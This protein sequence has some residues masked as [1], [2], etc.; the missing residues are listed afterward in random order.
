MNRIFKVIY[1]KVK[2][3][4]VVTSEF[5]KTNKKTKTSTAVKA[6]LLA[7]AI[8]A[9]FA[10]FPVGVPS[11]QAADS[12]TY[13]ESTEKAHQQITLDGPAGEGTLI[14]NLKNGMKAKGSTDAITGGQLWD[15]EQYIDEVK[16]MVTTNTN[17]LMKVNK[18]ISDH[19]T[20]L[21]QYSNRLGD[22]ENG[23]TIKVNGTEVNELNINNKSLKFGNTDTISVASDNNGTL[24]FNAATGQVE[25]DNNGLVTGDMVMRAIKKETEG[26]P[27]DANVANKL[28]KDLINLSEA[29]E[30]KLNNLVETAA[31]NKANVNAEGIDTEAWREKL[32][33]NTIEENESGF[34]T[35]DMMFSALKTFDSEY[36]YKDASNLDAVSISNWQEKLGNGMNVEG[37]TGLITGDT[38]NKALKD[39]QPGTGT[40]IKG[41]DTINV[42]DEGVVSVKANGEVKDNNTGI[43][44]GGQVSEAIKE[45]TKNIASDATVA[46]KASKDLDNLSDKGQQKIKDVMKADMDTKLDKGLSNISDEGKQVIKDTV[47]ADLDKKADITYVDGKVKD[48]NDKLETKADKSYVDNAVKNNVNKEELKTELDKKADISY[49]DSTVNDAVKD[50]VTKDE[51]SKGLEA[52]ADKKDLESKINADASNLTDENVKS[53][54]EKLGTGTVTE[55]NKNLVTGDEVYKAVMKVDGNKGLVTSDENSIYIGKNDSTTAINFKNSEGTARVLTGIKTDANDDTSAAN[56]G[57]VKDSVNN[58]YQNVDN[59]MNSMYNKLNSDM[60]KGIAGASALAALKPLDYDPDDKVTFAVGYGHYKGENAAALGLF[61]RPNE[62]TMLNVGTSLGSGNNAVNAGLSFKVGKGSTYNGLSKAEMAAEL[63]KQGQKIENLEKDNAELREKLEEI[64]AKM[65]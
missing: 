61:Y 30:T 13:D 47:K 39:I 28:D 2:G 20:K 24:R 35:S 56:V 64:L 45:A 54:T 36:A 25:L 38:L 48:L 6:T 29:G 19:G 32:A 21:I 7:L 49:V 46:S 62:N 26:L 22:L 1:D 65:K 42:T 33:A 15:T 37:N 10:S 8:P 3:N 31:S 11:V 41:S 53:W 43:V 59:A 57:Y 50:K 14:T 44:T 16:G 12:V 9:L 23:Y 40:T 17:T 52:K 58:V 60:S 51:L 5:G 18:S 55:N 63:V 4:Y 34:I 27:T